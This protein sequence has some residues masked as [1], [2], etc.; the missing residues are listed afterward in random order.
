MESTCKRVYSNGVYSVFR[1]ILYTGAVY[2][3]VARYGSA[4][5]D[6]SFREVSEAIRFADQK[7]KESETFDI[8]DF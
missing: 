4:F 3:S 1:R 5:W 6:K 7:K 8:M 2:F